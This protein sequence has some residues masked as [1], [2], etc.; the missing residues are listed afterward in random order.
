MLRVLPLRATLLSTAI[1]GLG[2][3]F[4]G[5]LGDAAAKGATAETVKSRIGDYVIDELFRAHELREFAVRGHYIMSSTTDVPLWVLTQQGVVTGLGDVDIVSQSMDVMSDHVV[6][7]GR[8]KSTHGSYRAPMK[9]F[10][11][12]RWYRSSDVRV[13]LAR[14]VF[15]VEFIVHKASPDTPVRTV[16]LDKTAYADTKTRDENISRLI[17]KRDE[18]RN[19]IQDFVEHSLLYKDG[20]ERVVKH[21]I[22][23]H[24]QHETFQNAFTDWDWKS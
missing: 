22:E 2:G 20:F 12:G 17:D 18:L 19:A 10:M 14:V 15:Y 11:D 23:T 8:F 3:T 21:I 5:A 16:R 7:K 9:I 4:R 24:R 13:I 6:Y 1:L